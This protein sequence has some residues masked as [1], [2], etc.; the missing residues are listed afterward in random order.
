[1]AKTDSDTE[2]FNR[3]VVWSLGATAVLLL[4][5]PMF[6]VLSH[7]TYYSAYVDS[8]DTD[9]EKF[10]QLST[11]SGCATDDSTISCNLAIAPIRVGEIP[12]SSSTPEIDM[13]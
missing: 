4:I 6:F 3:I 5:L 1:M 9:E 13:T 10:A 7:V 8:G 11:I 12:L 2:R